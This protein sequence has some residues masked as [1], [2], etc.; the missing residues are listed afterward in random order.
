MLFS[1]P[2]FAA[3]AVLACVACHASEKHRYECPSPL[4]DANGHH[5][6]THVDLFDG[7][8]QNQAFLQGWS[9]LKGRDIYLV[10]TYDGTTTVITIHAQGVDSCDATDKPVTAFCD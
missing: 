7:P 1:K 9:N 6:I 4:V 3:V 2:L 8:P 5:A 10:C